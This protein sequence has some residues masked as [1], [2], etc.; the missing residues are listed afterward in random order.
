MLK[1]II[2]ALRNRN[3]PAYLRC[4]QPEPR[5]WEGKLET[6]DADRSAFQ[7]AVGKSIGVEGAEAHA[8]FDYEN[9]AGSSKDDGRVIEGWKRGA[10]G[11]TIT[12]RHDR[13]IDG[14]W[15]PG[16]QSKSRLVFYNGTNQ[17]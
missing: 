16:S 3:I 2:S 6:R 5:S 17:E 4:D 8:G 9:L 14:P 12:F 10:D 13:L 11:E 15:P 7:H 1:K